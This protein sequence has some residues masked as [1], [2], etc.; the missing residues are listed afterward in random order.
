MVW[1]EIL[2]SDIKKVGKI[3]VFNPETARMFK[4]KNKK[5]NQGQICFSL[6]YLWPPPENEM[7][8]T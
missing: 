8:R 1:M 2:F 5:K 6:K 4:G 7:V 3:I